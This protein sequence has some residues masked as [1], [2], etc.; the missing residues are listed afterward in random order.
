MGTDGG[1]RMRARELAIAG[2]RNARAFGDPSWLV[3]S[4]AI[5]GLTGAGREALRAEG[6]TVVVDLREDVELAPTGH[7]LP[8]VR[9]PLYGTPAGPP[10]LGSLEGVAR[11]LLDE[12][13]P[14]L[15]RAVAAIADADG[16]ALVHCAVGK[17]RTGIVV[18]L[19]LLAAGAAPADVIADYARSA[20]SVDPS[21]AVEVRAAMAELDVDEAVR[22]AALRLHLESPPAAMEHAIERIEAAGGAVA[23]LLA[24]GVG[25]A[26]IDRLRAKLAAGTTA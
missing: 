14:Q 2:A 26:R 25:E 16:A 1:M 11:A 4:A 8:V 21:R 13:L 3:R 6:V 7:G 15:G 5:D 9:I 18:A 24:A 19:A 10:L 20:G 22:A 23:L 12:R 17:D